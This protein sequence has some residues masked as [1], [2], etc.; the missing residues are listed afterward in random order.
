MSSPEATNHETAQQSELGV[1]LQQRAA[2][3]KRFDRRQADA[4]D[5]D[6]EQSVRDTARTAAEELNKQIE[7]IDLQINQLNNRAEQEARLDALKAKNPSLVMVLHS[8]SELRQTAETDEPLDKI[9]V[10]KALEDITRVLMEMAEAKKAQPAVIASAQSE[11]TEPIN[12]AVMPEAS[13]PQKPAEGEGVVKEVTAD[14]IEDVIVDSEMM[15]ETHVSERVGEALRDLHDGKFVSLEYTDAHMDLKDEV[16]ISYLDEDGTITPSSIENAR[17]L[18]GLVTDED[19]ARFG[20][21]DTDGYLKMIVAQDSRVADLLSAE[22]QPQ[23]TEKAGGITI[24]NLKALRTELDSID[25]GHSGKERFAIFGGKLKEMNAIVQKVLAENGKESNV[26]LRHIESTLEN[27]AGS[28]LSSSQVRMFETLAYIAEGLHLFDGTAIEFIATDFKANQDQE[29]FITDATLENEV[30]QSLYQWM[31]Y[32]AVALEYKIGADPSFGKKME[33]V[34][35]IRDAVPHKNISG[36]LNKATPTSSAGDSADTNLHY[37]GGLN[38]QP[39]SDEKLT[40]TN[41]P[42]A[43]KGTRNSIPPEVDTRHAGIDMHT[44]PPAPD[45]EEPNE[46]VDF[47][48]DSVK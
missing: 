48:P 4:D 7:Q 8:V 29:D 11:A 21:Q 3:Q 18:M 37:K 39:M 24:I 14:D 33:K 35:K 10:I 28:S 15:T 19:M 16:G 25:R 47:D 40:Q 13:A 6:E 17:I 38:G 34:L 41:L 12:E 43:K 36:P 45:H 31:K 42:P 9:M 26:T 22:P 1:L 46:N 30:R 27:Q 20:L 44:K 2:L 32:I 23:K 5:E